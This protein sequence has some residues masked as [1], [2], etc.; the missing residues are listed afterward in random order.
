MLHLSSPN[1][2]HFNLR[3]YR[4][5]SSECDTSCAKLVSVTHFFVWHEEYHF[6]FLLSYPHNEQA[7]GTPL[8]QY[9]ISE[10]SESNTKQE[11]PQLPELMK[12]FLEARTNL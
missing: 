6:N 7:H 12:I 11:Y 5:V 2:V 4:L 10:V 9:C 1:D 3:P 8:K